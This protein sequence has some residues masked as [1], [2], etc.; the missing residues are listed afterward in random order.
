MRWRKR[1]AWLVALAL[2]WTALLGYWLPGWIKPRIEAAATEALGTPVSFTALKIQP[3]LGVVTLDGLRVGEARAPLLTLE[4]AQV[5]LSLESVWRLAPVL[6]RVSL[7]KPEVFIERW[8]A[9]EFNFT[10]V[11]RHVLNKPSTPPGSGEPM[12]FA[13]FNITLKDG[14]VH[15]SD[16]VLAQTHRIEQLQIG[17]PF[18]SN[19][20][21]AQE[22][23]VMPL[24]SAK[25]D[26]SALLI[27]GRTLPFAQGHRSEV[28]LQLDGV[29]VSHWLEALQP[30]LPPELKM[31]SRGGVLSTALTVAFEAPPAPQPARLSVRGGLQVNGLG[32]SWPSLPG[33]GQTDVAWDGLSVQGID[34]AP[35]LRDV[36]IGQ[37]KLSGLQWHHE[38]PVAKHGAGKGAAPAEQLQ[39]KAESAT[40]AAPW[41]W[42]VGEVSVDARKV[43]AQFWRPSASSVRW[44]VFTAMSA[45][46]KGLDSREKAKPAAWSL[47]LHDEH[48]G[49][50]K[51]SGH[52]Q[53]STLQLD[54]QL[55]IKA[56][57]LQPW[58]APVLPTL[59][60]QVALDQGE[61]NL[62]ARLD[63]RLQPDAQH[64]PMAQVQASLLQINGLQTRLGN[65]LAA[66]DAV[67]LEQLELA[68]A[69]AQ[70]DLQG[71]EP[72]QQ[73]TIDA[74]RLRG[75]DVSLTRG[76][77]GEWLGM[78]PSVPNVATG[79]NVNT[80]ANTSAKADP[81]AS[82][83][84]PDVAL[85][86]FSCE[87]CQV[88]FTDQSVTPAAH[89][90]VTQAELQ[91]K[92]LSTHLDQPVQADLKALAQGRGRVQFAGQVRP[93]PLSVKGKVLVVGLDL[94]EVQPYIDP[95]VNI[96]VAGAKAHAEG[97]VQLQML[98]SKAGAPSGAASA[99]ASGGMNL[100][101]QGRAG[102]SDVRVLDRVNDAE[103]LHWQKLDLSGL[104]IKLANDALD[105]D[106]GRI[107]LNDFYGRIIINPDGQLNLAGI[108]RQQAGAA[109]SSLTT[110]QAPG[111]AASAASSSSAASAPT[112]TNMASI[113]TSQA[114]TA[115]SASAPD[116]G[117][118]QRPKPELR[119]QHIQ[120]SKGEFDFT[121]H[122]I[123]PNYSARLTQIEGEVSAVASSKPEPA[124][125]RLAGAVDDSAPLL[126]T[127]QLHPLGPRLFTDIQGSAKGIEMTR[128][129]PYAGRY[130]GYAIEKGSLSVTVHYKVEGG[131]LEASNQVFLDQLTFGEK[132]DSPD[133]LK[134]PVLFAVSLLKD[135][136]GQID[137][138]L[139]ISGSL[140]DPQ[141][142]VG[143]IIWR[144]IVN[145]I[146]KAVMAPF[147][148]LSGGDS[149]EL[150][151]V[152]FDGGSAELSEA[153]SK[154]L[155][156]LATKLLDR[157]ALKL[158]ATGRADP[159]SD[160]EGLRR[161]HVLQL[162]RAAKAKSTGEP[163][164]EVQIGPEERLT[165]LTAAYKAADIKKPRNALG[166]AKTLS[167]EEMEKLLKAAAPADNE[168][169][170]LLANRR[171]DV[172]KAYLVSKLPPERVLLTA[173]KLGA[174][175]LPE[176]DK[177]SAARVQ[178]TIK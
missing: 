76:S 35:L 135:R 36:A 11:L 79:A 152:P 20:A 80:S 168:A 118:A 41:Q 61:L 86:A 127:G 56:L 136:K 37:V 10:P 81:P 124:T 137:I 105:A 170:K 175:G 44:P 163:A 141:F 178:F 74:L 111:V 5:Q 31:A 34:A 120:L 59:P 146:T 165:W 89:V 123:K 107:A 101:Y 150:G 70:L 46:V 157:P 16:R 102:L 169:L 65:N 48:E 174:E 103:F 128:F 85:K 30:L 12:H 63:A 57:K 40:P 167:A 15:Y 90:Q 83:P 27:K 99:S 38:A 53:L 45:N 92:D 108:M 149:D 58:A 158:E 50:I 21:S 68:G 164:D 100:R 97:Q 52:V 9:S 126:I 138:N 160:A 140:D 22:V 171:A 87:A 6:R 82:K 33:L 162:M 154:R 95:L 2:A 173:S 72:L 106:L 47:S 13:V 109:P 155:D 115:H 32:V 66:K 19:L 122:Y 64:P 147:S 142:S 134:L 177:G 3:W 110:P 156:T 18:I 51:A 116:A 117:T 73:L 55:D 91:L 60:L 119:W 24:L 139:P 131:K 153:A 166:L 172:V 43:D 1:L 113:S 14:V 93:E 144:V 145:L 132:V 125:L 29:D 88:R 17:V 8:S 159:I 49:D 42:R 84:L 75:L 28:D 71:A 161:A 112:T 78:T 143:G 67:R 96:T 62:Q 133:A 23:E 98:A 151:L 130:A 121:D 4:Q 148:L 94:R 104:D 176:G 114:S 7:V 39:A 129:S 69:Q 25:V 26:G 77:Q 54:G